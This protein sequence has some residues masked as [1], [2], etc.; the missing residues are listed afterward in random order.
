MGN[1]KRITENESYS[2]P[3]TKENKKYEE[4]DKQTIPTHYS[5][6]PGIRFAPQTKDVNYVDVDVKQVQC[7]GNTE[8]KDHDY[9][10]SVKSIHVDSFNDCMKILGGLD[11]MGCYEESE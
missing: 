1:F 7:R 5:S 11:L 8:A 6:K 10:V 4:I 2:N 3:T 9:E